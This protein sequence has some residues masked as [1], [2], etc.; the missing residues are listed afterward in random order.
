[1]AKYSDIK[2]FTVQTLSSD[3]AASIAET[4]TWASGTSINTGRLQLGGTGIESASLVFGGVV[5]PPN[6]V[7]NTESWNGTAWTEVNDLNTARTLTGQ[8]FGTYTAA[9][10][11]TGSTSGPG[12]GMP[13][14]VESWNGTSWTEV[15]DMAL[16]REN[17]GATTVGT[18]VGTMAVGGNSD[19]TSP[20]PTTITEDWNV[21]AALSTVTIS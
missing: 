15:A 9:I 14:A 19:F 5:S 18:A 2:G 3:P 4:G 11:G 7:A 1:M 10:A 17:C 12:T 6:T 21:D 8:G 16:R 20:N 13:G